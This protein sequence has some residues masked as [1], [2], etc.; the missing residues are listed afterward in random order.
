MFFCQ[1][2]FIHLKHQKMKVHTSWN[3]ENIKQEK[4]EAHEF[5]KEIEKSV[6]TIADSTMKTGFA[7]SSTN[8]WSKAARADNT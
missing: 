4:I 5:S 7:K 1:T 2:T 3:Y 8:K 6:Q